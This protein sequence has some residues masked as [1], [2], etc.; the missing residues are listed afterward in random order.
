M[1]VVSHF[2]SMSPTISIQ[3]LNPYDLLIDFD[4]DF[5]IMFRTWMQSFYV[6]S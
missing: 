3:V 4:N 1:Q 5:Q 2:I 6:G